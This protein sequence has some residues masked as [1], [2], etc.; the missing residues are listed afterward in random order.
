M[1]IKLQDIF[2]GCIVI[3]MVMNL[4]ILNVADVATVYRYITSVAA[5]IMGILCIFDS[6]IYARIKRCCHFMNWWLAI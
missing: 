4:G 5:I 1:K 2:M 3:L 6:R